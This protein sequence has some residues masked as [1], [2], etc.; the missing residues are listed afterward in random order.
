MLK[1][2][3]SFVFLIVVCLSCCF[4]Q[5]LAQDCEQ[6]TA[7]TDL[8]INNVKARLLVGGDLWWD[9]DGGKYIV[10]K[11]EV[12]EPEVTAF[13]AAGLWLG[14]FDP[15]GN[16][17]MAA[18]TYGTANGDTDYWPGPLGVNG[19][20]TVD[21]CNNF[22]RF[23]ET[24]SADINAHKADWNDNGVIDG[25]VPHSV[26]A[27]PGKDNPHFQSIHGFELP[28][29]VQ[30][31]APFYDRNGNNIYDPETGDYPDINDADQG[32]WW[33]FN[34]AGGVHSETGG[35]PLKF[36]IQVLAYAFSSSNDNIN[37]A[38]FYDYKIINRALEQLDSVHV[39]IWVDISLGCSFDDYFG[40]DT[41]NDLAFIYNLDSIDG[42]LS[43][44]DCGLGYCDGIPVAGIKILKGVVDLENNIEVE[45]GLSS[46]IYYNNAG[47]N[48]PP[49]PGTEDP[50]SAHEFYNY[51]TGSWRDGL[52]ITYGGNGHN[53]SGESI[54]HV[55]TDP[56]DDVNGWSMCGEDMPYG[57]RRIVIGSGPFRLDP[58]AVTDLS[59]AALFVEDVPHPCPDISPLLEAAEIAQN[60]FDGIISPT[61][62]LRQQVENIQFQPNP[63]TSQAELVFN[64]LENS[65]QQVSIYS[66]EGKLMRVYDSNFGKSLTIEKGALSQRMYF[67]KILTDDFKVYSGKFVVQ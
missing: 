53:P 17:K 51:L 35:I 50:S 1:P 29:T 7:Q 48:P 67:Y 5:I 14:G 11:P 30:G 26:L 4:N 28:S 61:E 46:F 23:W 6:S 62:V 27:W 32:F 31:M 20:T 42:E 49:P 16:L 41:L 25:P 65:V 66:I 13:K 18:Q 59:F 9:S 36:E 24:Y 38:T 22:D 45:R 33:V 63:M 19:T 43:C 60:L 21:V 56:P 3:H 55:F 52:G 39:G 15:G 40:C 8:D 10:P 57:Q 34:D 12:G 58:G 47:T 64:E 2:K 37:N 44:Y 54:K